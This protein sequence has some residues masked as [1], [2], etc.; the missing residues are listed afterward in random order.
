MGNT[1]GQIYYEKSDNDNAIEKHLVKLMKKHCWGIKVCIDKMI[2]ATPPRL[3]N[4][5]KRYNK[6]TCEVEGLWIPFNG[7]E[8]KTKERLTA[9]FNEAEE[10]IATFGLLSVSYSEHQSM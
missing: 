9:F 10:Y 7:G 1:V 8:D 2:V 3:P 4:V 5:R 6:F